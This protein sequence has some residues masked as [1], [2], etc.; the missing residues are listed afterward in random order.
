MTIQESFQEIKTIV[1]PAAGTPVFRT[2][3]DEI[4]NEIG[5]SI[6]VREQEKPPESPRAGEFV[7]WVN[8][9]NA[10]SENKSVQKSHR[11]FFQMNGDGSGSL[12]ASWTSLLYAL[13]RKVFEEMWGDAVSTVQA[14]QTWKVPFRWVRAEYD[15]LITQTSRTVGGVDREAY[16]RE[17]ARLGYT[18]AEVN[19]LAGPVPAETGVPGENY[20]R[21]YTYCAAPD[22]FVETHWSKGTYSEDYL[23]ANLETLKKNAKLALKYGLHPGIL[24][25]EPRNVPETLLERYPMV[26]GPR[27][28]HPFRSFKPRYTLSTAHPLVR[29]Y[30]AELMQNLLKEVPELSYMTI[31]TNDSGA[32]M[33]HTNS[34]YVGRNGGAFLIREWKTHEDIAKAAGENVVRFLKTLK[35]AASE[36]NPEFRVI[37]RID[38]LSAEKSYITPQLEAGLDLESAT[39]LAKNW[40]QPYHHVFYDDLKEVT[41]TP[42]LVDFWPEEK[43]EIESL[44]RTG[45]EGHIV[46]TFGAANTFE[47]L[48]GIPFPWL[49]AEKLRALTAGE[50]RN[51]AARGGIV[52][53][54]L[55]PWNINQ[56]MIRRIQL[57]DSRPVD[58]IIQAIAENWVGKRKETLV[59]LW[60]E[61]DAAIRAYPI[62][63]TL[64]SVWAFPWYRFWARPFVPNIG[65][66][67]E[68]DREYYERFTLVT[69]HNPARVDFAQDVLFKLCDQKR[70][71][72]SIQR[73]EKN[74]FPRIHAAIDLLNR[75]IGEIPENDPARSVFIDQRDRIRGLKIWF[76]TQKNVAAWIAGVHGYLKAETPEEKSHWKQVTH[77]M[78]LDELEDARDLLDL[79]EHSTTRFMAVSSVGETTFIYG[80]NLGDL[81]RK[82]IA[83]MT[84]RENDEPYID[85]DYMWRIPGVDFE[86]YR[87]YL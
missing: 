12:K 38:P 36:I 6:R 9:E 55:A 43:Q 37:L 74:L 69:P 25:F 77:D 1:I 53:S 68:K 86:E 14:G 64:Y 3:V 85:P 51:L 44:R 21:F 60:R 87:Q 17:M 2:I 26:R 32:G 78:V 79:W 22:Q 4:R 56:E 23:Q 67:P 42:Y 7:V 34:L 11:L 76:R 30:Y 62:P 50:V 10:V 54:G 24:A 58:D 83:L 45:S 63:V 66:I 28:D 35:N 15:L 29:A 8:D 57:G 84:G 70:A 49:A 52:P 59:R 82:K 73:M 31:W 39:F 71:V 40:V 81:I 33:E 18:H 41:E 48:L 72:Q 27:V 47:P 19:A 46:V 75:T 80:E 5:T 16:F 20:P 61:T 65:A 13:W